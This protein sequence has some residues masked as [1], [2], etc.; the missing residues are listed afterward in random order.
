MSEWI[1]Q[2]L[3]Q[4]HIQKLNSYEQLASRK[5][6]KTT[7]IIFSLNHKKIELEFSIFSYQ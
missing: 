5:D 7:Y 1:I 2:N 6:E 4:S 3:K